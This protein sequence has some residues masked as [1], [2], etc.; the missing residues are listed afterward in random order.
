MSE[1]SCSGLYNWP[2]D[3]FRND[4]K[5]YLKARRRIENE[6]TD[7]P[8]SSLQL[9]AIE[10]TYFFRLKSVLNWQ[11]LRNMSET[12]QCRN[13]EG[14]SKKKKRSLGRECAAYGCT[15]TFY[16]T[17]GAA[18]GLHFFGFPKKNSEKLRWCNL[19]K[20]EEGRDGFKVTS[21]TVL[22]E[23]HFT[24]KDMKRNPHHWRLV[25]GAEP[26]LN[27]FTSS[28]A[29]VKPTPRKPPAARSQPLFKFKDP[30]SSFEVGTDYDGFPDASDQEFSG[31][32]VSVSTQTDFSFIDLPVHLESDSGEAN[33][34]MKVFTESNHL[35]VQVK[36]L[37]SQISSLMTQLEKLEMQVAE[38]KKCRFS[39]DK[40]KDDNSA[41][42]F[43]TGFPNFSSLFATYEYLAPKLS[44]MHYW[45]GNKSSDNSNLS[46][47]EKSTLKPGQKRSLS[48]LEEF[49]LV[50]MRLKVGLLAIDLADRFGIS[51]A[52]VSKI[53]TTWICFLYHELPTLFPF[54]SQDLVRKNMPPQFKL[55]PNTRIIIDCTEIFIEVPSSMKS[56]SQTWSEYKHHN[57]YKALIG[58]SPAGCVTFVSKLWSGKVSDKEITLKSGVLALLEDGDTVMADRGFD[59]EDILPSGVSLNIPPF[60]GTRSQLTAK[61]VEK[62]AC[63]A[64]VRIHVERAIGR[65]KNFHILDGVL[66]LSLHPL[67]DQIFTVCSLLT[68]F[69]PFLV[70]PNPNE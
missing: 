2:I 68:N 64:S 19:I 14:V 70:D 15:N 53:F 47:H 3:P 39:I 21:A 67:A 57:T 46:Y 8:S 1:L 49:V 37:N 34:I 61:E 38:L 40:I 4:V 23:K 29:P 9:P 33:D 13:A 25:F 56:Q 58:I 6:I 5:L 55:Y 60:K 45:R 26:S 50:L 11:N 12:I 41:T 66:S 42:K 69:L 20:R 43:Y 7:D 16:N 54:P 52:Q 31:S 51:T 32:A 28:V 35:K 24:D 63:I 18:T 36:E 48:H 17:E 22:C 59:I 65:I 30:V 44:R 27:L 10:I 62:T